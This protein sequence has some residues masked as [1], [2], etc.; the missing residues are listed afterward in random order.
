MQGERE[1]GMR[2]F[3][4]LAN[5]RYYSFEEGDPRIKQMLAKEDVTDKLT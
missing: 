5:D 3:H 1:V 2:V 4:N